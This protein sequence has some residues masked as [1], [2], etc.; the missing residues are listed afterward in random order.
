MSGRDK[1]KKEIWSNTQRAINQWVV[2]GVTKDSKICATKGGK[3]K[4]IAGIPYGS[5]TLSVVFQWR[6]I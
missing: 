1:C 3:R 5:V 6:Q 2:C 4:Q